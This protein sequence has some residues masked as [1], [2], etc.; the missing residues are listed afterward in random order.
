MEGPRKEWLLSTALSRANNLPVFDYM[1]LPA[2]PTAHR[3]V[4]EAFRV[5][6]LKF[7]PLLDYVQITPELIAGG[8]CR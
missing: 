3:E 7:C 4:Q 6:S 2:A 8:K 1:K 5:Y